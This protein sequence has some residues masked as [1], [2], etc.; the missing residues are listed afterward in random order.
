MGATRRTTPEPLVAELG[1]GRLV[2]RIV[3][4]L[5]AAGVASDPSGD[6]A[7]VVAWD[8]A[9][10]LLTVDLLVE[11]VDFDLSYCTPADIGWK[12]LAVSVS[13]IAAMGGAARHAVVALALRADTRVAFVD[14]LTRGLSEAASRWDVAIAGGDLSRARDL[15]ISVAL[16]GAPGPDG[17]ARR[18]GAGPEDAIFVTGALGGAAG[19]LALLQAGRAT[20]P[21]HQ[22]DAVRRLIQRQLRPQARASEGPALVRAGATAMIDVSDGL[23]ID[24]DRLVRASGV[25]CVVDLDAVPVDAD[26]GAVDLGP[27]AADARRLALLGGEDFELLVTGPPDAAGSMTA[28][29]A[30]LGTPLTRI[31]R[32]DEEERL[33]GGAPLDEWTEQAWDHLRAR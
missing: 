11:S 4:S 25:G 6:D 28:A 22:P 14:E 23:A 3:E 2:E 31:G 21:D 17:W 19:G 20:G 27:D 8:D 10:L 13:D 9:H 29:A 26:L 12:A 18:S 32:V 24:L 1:E 15:S 33:L 30:E 16:T 7:A 5:R